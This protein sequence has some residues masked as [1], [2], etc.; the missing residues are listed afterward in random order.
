MKL[1][2]QMP[3]RIFLEQEDVVKIVAES[4]RGSFGILPNRL[5][6]IAYLVPGIFL[7]ELAGKDEFYIAVDCG[8]LVKDGDRVSVSVHNAIGDVPLA[9]L[10]S[11]VDEQLRSLDEQEMALRNSISLLQSSMIGSFGRSRS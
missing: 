4:T 8:I 11:V 1:S 6:C 10:P 3:S 5:D 9:D 2:I 7:Y